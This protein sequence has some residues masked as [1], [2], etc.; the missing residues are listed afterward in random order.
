MFGA[1]FAMFLPLVYWLRHEHSNWHNLA[2]WVSAAAILGAISSMSSGPIMMAVIAACCLFMEHHKRWVKPLLYM[3]I[4][5]SILIEVLS[6]RHFYHVLLSYLN[7]IG[8]SWWHRARLIDCAIEHFGE[9][10]LAGYGGQDPG[11]GQ[12]LGADFT[13]VTNEFVLA[14]VSYGILGVIALCSVLAVTFFCLFRLYNSTDDPRIKSLAWAFGSS[15]VAVI[16]VFMSVSFFGQMVTLLYCFYGMVGSSTYIT[17][18]RVGH[19]QVYR[20]IF[21]PEKTGC[22]DHRVQKF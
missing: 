13:D 14:G 9:W 12:Y 2:Y 6:N 4:L 5:A 3:F 8:G 10:G 1:W 17:G 19:S 18:P 22:T 11:W 7:P 16:V 20:H 21:I 15:M